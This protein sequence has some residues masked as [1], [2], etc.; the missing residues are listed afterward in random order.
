LADCWDDYGEGVAGEDGAKGCEENYL[1]MGGST[2]VW[3]AWCVG[4][5]V[6]T[7]GD[8]VE[9]VSFHFKNEALEL[10]IKT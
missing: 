6:G 10:V 8:V 1:G 4:V 9:A 5:G 3:N 7:Y 2:R